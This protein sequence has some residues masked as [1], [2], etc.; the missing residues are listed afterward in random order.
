MSLHRRISFYL[1]P[2]MLAAG[3][4][5]VSCIC[6]Q[7]IHARPAASER[8]QDNSQLAENHYF[9]LG[10]R[11]G[12]REYKGKHVK[13]LNAFSHENFKRAYDE[14]YQEGIKGKR[15]YRIDHR[16]SRWAIIRSPSEGARP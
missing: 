4:V 15:A 5:S 9:N 3:M 1:V 6:G 8:D 16:L 11:D 12:Y 13:H 2:L 7:T 10:N 14:G